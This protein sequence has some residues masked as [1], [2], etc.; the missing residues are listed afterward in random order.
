MLRIG[1]ETASLGDSG[2]LGDRAWA[3]VDRETGKVASAR[4]ESTVGASVISGS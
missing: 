4:P 3:L 2:L 1:V